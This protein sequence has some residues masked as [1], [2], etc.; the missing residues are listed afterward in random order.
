MF[1]RPLILASLNVKGLRRDSPK[2]K[3]IKAWM[4][5]LPSL[6]Q[7][8]LI[9]EHHLGKEDIQN[10]AKGLE[11]WNGTALWNEGISMGRS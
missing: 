7:V 8:L 9:L 5:S 2:P 11:F 4:A 3:E 1:E 6:P 10:S